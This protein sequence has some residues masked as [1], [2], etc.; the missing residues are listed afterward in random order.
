MQEA[1][2][3]LVLD[4]PLVLPV[5]RTLLQHKGFLVLSAETA[6]AALR[7]SDDRRLRIDLL[8]AEVV[9]P[10]TSGIDLVLQ[11]RA[12]R[13]DLPVLLTS[14]LPMDFW[15]A[16]DSQNLT[17]LPNGSYSFLQKPFT[18]QSLMKC[19]EELLGR[20]ERHPAEV[21]V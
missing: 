14:G 20:Q 13:P 11:T 9:L 3:A 19:V 6:E 17:E 12:T 5:F 1:R 10:E 15:P 8:V 4:Q 7:W 16:T 21:A 18:V 2:T